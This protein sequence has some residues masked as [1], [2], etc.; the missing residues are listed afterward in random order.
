MKPF[1]FTN[2]DCRVVDPLFSVFRAGDCADGSFFPD[3]PPA[4]WETSL[5]EVWDAEGVAI[6]VPLPFID[7]QWIAHA[8]NQL[9]DSEDK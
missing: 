6:T 9:S 3:K 1:P 4:D 5:F 8:M 7:C 2:I